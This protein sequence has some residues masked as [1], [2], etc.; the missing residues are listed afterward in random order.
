[1][2][3]ESVLIPLR[4]CENYEYFVKK[5]YSKLAK[6]APYRGHFHEHFYL[7]LYEGSFAS[8]FPEYGI[9]SS[10]RPFRYHSI[11]MPHV[12]ER[13]QINKS[14]SYFAH[15][16]VGQFFNIFLSAQNDL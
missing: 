5:C 4:F 1:M 2:A 12:V 10:Y 3:L 15:F 11:I 14:L 6:I 16:S 8:A 7:I 9:L 13:V